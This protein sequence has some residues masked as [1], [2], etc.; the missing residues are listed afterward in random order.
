M[1]WYNE[2]IIDSRS[3]AELRQEIATLAASYTPEWQFD[4]SNPDIG[5]TIA[6]IFSE[7]MADN[8]R[9]LN[10]V[11][12]NYH[13][14]FVNMLGISLLPA[15]PASGVAVIKL[16]RDTVPGLPLLKG[17]KLVGQTYGDGADPIIFETLGDVYITSAQLTDIVSIS[18]KFG[19]IIPLRG[20][21][22]APTVLPSPK[23]A[24]DTEPQLQPQAEEDGPKIRNA[25]PLFDYSQPGVS[26]NI[27]VF[28]H[29]TIFHTGAD[30]DIQ[31]AIQGPARPATALG[32]SQR[33]RWSHVSAEGLMPFATV[34]VEDNVISLHKDAQV[35]PLDLGGDSYGLI[36]VE[37]LEG[38]DTSVDVTSLQFTSTCQDAFPAYLS[39]ND[40]ELDRAHFLPF[41]NSASLFD[42]CYLGHEHIFH[43]DGALISMTFHLSSQEHL[44]T[45]T[46][47]QQADSLKIIKRKP[48]T[49]PFETVATCPQEVSFDYFNGLGWRKLP[50][51]HDY[52]SLF[53]GSHNGMTTISF[54]CPDDWC[55]ITVGAYHQRCIRMRVNR[56]D[57]CYLQPCI[58]TMPVL[59]NIKLSYLYDQGWKL[60]HLV[61][62][63]HGTRIED[64]TQP[65]LEG[66]S[67]PLFQPLPY[68]G[69]AL[70]LG[71]DQ[72]PQGSPVSLLF[73][74][75]ESIH[76]QSAPILY[77]YATL[78]G[79]KPLKVIDGTQNMTSAGTVLFMPPSDMAPT[80]VEGVVRYWIRLVDADNVH[81]DPDHHHPLIRAIY[82]NAVEIQ[83]IETL[84]EEDFY[85][86]VPTPSMSFALA[87]ENIL[88][89]TVYVNEQNRLSQPSMRRFLQE[90]PDDV[91]ATFNFLGDI[92]T[93][94][95]RWTEVDNFDGSM[96]GDRHYVIDRMNNT[97]SFGDGVNVMIP[98]AQADVAFTVQCTSCRGERGNLPR[99]AVNN[100]RGRGLYIEAIYNPIATYAGS[101]IE[102]LNS[103][104]LRG[105]SILSGRGRLVSEIDFIREVKA[106]SSSIDK[107][108]CIAGLDLDGKE[109]PALITI[110]VMMQ[111]FA[112][113][114]Y[115]FNSLKDRLRRR[116]LSRCE[117]TLAP[118]QLIVSEPV[119]ISISLSVWAESY[120]AHRSFE[121]QSLIHETLDD[122]LN[123]LDSS[124]SQGWDIGSLP[125]TAQL[126][127]LLHAMRGPGRVL[128][129]LATAR[130]VDQTGSHERSLEELP[131]NPFAIAIPG[132]HRIYIE[133]P[134]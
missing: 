96:P 117:A 103:A 127:M 75:A 81:D 41:G 115:S 23:E 74:V 116:I 89:T 94:F 67:V 134:N 72:R 111:D 93:F 33:Y 20:G 97:I 87:A 28:Y 118:D 128:R 6:L 78:S 58:H 7:Q 44:V 92:Q 130:Y 108:R 112:D 34:S 113:G 38:V 70:Y 64:I 90:H 26:R 119:Y 131:Y 66:R 40:Q 13:T 63:I 3:E 100:L 42:E 5:S 17:T 31:V 24:Q 53:D 102:D 71:F 21:P 129:F 133:L 95:V 110:A 59:E 83:N 25:I 43:Q 54:R 123:P 56:A 122:F 114:A 18:R 32:D 19:K 84:D 37:A 79:W 39:H 73:D 45:F 132:N 4:P 9:R 98:T 99:G 86:Q 105:A 30:V 124:H 107:V 121:L 47:Q 8:I 106:F 62:S 49:I 51:L 125:T 15:F 60:P 126:G 80:S 104:R 50:C 76:F 46:P 52:D 29:R 55:P 65:I 36:C 82:P 11:M 10:Q 69:N 2:L 88:S 22:L 1:D 12:D 109:N 57:N 35:E 77:E 68:P 91:R 27:A 61:Q 120:D 85:I 14:E 48:T 16:I 101:N